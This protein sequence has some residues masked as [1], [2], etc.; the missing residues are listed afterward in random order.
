MATET[1]LIKNLSKND[2]H[3][4]YGGFTSSSSDLLSKWFSSLEARSSLFWLH[5]LNCTFIDD[6]EEEEFIYKS[7]EENNA[8]NV[9][10][11]E[12]NPLSS[13]GN[14]DNYVASL[15]AVQNKDKSRINIDSLGVKI[16]DAT[17]FPIAPCNSI[18]HRDTELLVALTENCTHGP[19][20]YFCR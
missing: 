2:L 11:L 12:E 4:N 5:Y 13:A 14:C 9:K 8:E 19:V 18:A 10:N 6:E 15:V 16:G 3:L 1:L 20:C 7:K 17:K